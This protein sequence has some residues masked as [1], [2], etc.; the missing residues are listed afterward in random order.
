MRITTKLMW[1]RLV[2]IKPI[3]NDDDLRATFQRLESL[4]QA[5]EG[6]PEADEREV[7]VALVE[8]YDHHSF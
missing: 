2:T 5:A 3:R 1:R 7:L 8:A 6:S 4:F